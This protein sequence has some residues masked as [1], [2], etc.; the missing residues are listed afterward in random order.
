MLTALFIAVAVSYA[1]TSF[2]NQNHTPNLYA[3]APNWTQTDWSGGVGTSTTTQ[4]SSSS[5][6]TTAIAGQVGLGFNGEE[7]SNTGLESDLTGWNVEGSVWSFDGTT[8]SITS[9]NGAAGWEADGHPRSGWMVSL[10]IKTSAS[11]TQRT[12]GY[13]AHS[14]LYCRLDVRSDGKL[15]VYGRLGGALWPGFIGTTVVND[16]E[17]HHI[18][19]R[20]T[21]TT[22]ETYVDG[23]LDQTKSDPDEIFPVYYTI[24]ATSTNGVAINGTNQQ[25]DGLMTDVAIFDNELSL[26]EIVNI[27]NGGVPRDESSESLSGYLNGYWRA[28]NSSIGADNVLDQSGSSLDGTMG[29]MEEEDILTGSP[30][31]SHNSNQTYNSSSGSVKVAGGTANN[32]FTQTVN[33]GD[34]N[35]YHLTAYAYTD[36][37]AVTSAD[38]ELYANG[39]TISTTYTD[40]GSGWYKLSGVATGVASDTAYGVQVKANKQVYL[41]DFSLSRYAE[42][43]TLTS[44]IYDTTLPAQWGTITL[45]TGGTGT[46]AVRARTDENDDMSTA[47]SFGSCDPITSGTDLTDNNCVTDLDQY[48]QY[49]VTLSATDTSTTPTFLEWDLDYITDNV[50]PSITLTPLTPDP[51]ADNTPTLSGSVTDLLGTINTVEYQIDGTSGSWSTCP[52]TDGSYNSA[53]EAFTCTTTTLLDGNRTIYIRSTDSNNN[54]T[55][56]ASTVTDDFLVDATGPVISNLTATNQT[57]NTRITWTTDEIASSQ[58]AYGLTDTYGN[59]TTLADTNPRVTSHNVLIPDNTLNCGS[60][61]HY[62]V[63]TID[64]LLNQTQSSDQTFTA[65]ACS[66]SGGGGGGSS[67]SVGTTTTTTVTQPATT[68]TPP[69]TTETPTPITIV[70]QQA[71][72]SGGGGGSSGSRERTGGGFLSRFYSTVGSD[73]PSSEVQVTP[74]DDNTVDV[75]VE[76]L[77]AEDKPVEGAKVTLYSDPVTQYTDRRGRA[78]F[79]NIAKGDH[80]LVISYSGQSGQQRLRVD[81]DVR[82]TVQME[83]VQVE[84]E[85]TFTERVRDFFRFCWLRECEG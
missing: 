41:D 12:F 17:W 47:P 69:P 40:M 83:L 43:G 36:G 73:R 39:S 20:R 61:Y 53:T 63:T 26:E 74:Q 16:G 42:T 55:P 32:E 66:E 4:F 59:T 54:T 58:V 68:T 37:S 45:T 65:P 70:E 24:G 34:T 49:Q 46:I 21:A 27:Y 51:T 8:E 30:S 72:T 11:H 5:N 77:D 84:E 64:T 1:P 2:V 22:I 44:A 48:I 82:L 31:M 38:V 62:Q 14:T 60:T 18:V 9:I 7:F 85:Q 29:N 56:N 10:W 23:V 52:P 79:S 75:T 78:F 57:G 81:G 76:V 3:A 67:T 19:L 50:P 13:Q 33:V 28:A 6:A 35:Q 25:F 71:T 15:Q 80:D